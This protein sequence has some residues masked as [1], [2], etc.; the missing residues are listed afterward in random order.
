MTTFLPEPER[1]TRYFTVIS[2]D[3]HIVEPPEMFLRRV[4]TKFVARAPRV[5]REA[6]G[7]EMWLYDGELIPNIGLNAVA[8]RPPR[9]YSRDPVTFDDMRRG[10]W[11]IHA[12]IADMDLDGVFA[13]LNFPSFLTGFGGGRLQTTTKDQDL[14]LAV[15][16]AWNDWHLEEWAGSYPDRIIPCQITWLHNPVLAA[17]DVERNR[18]R[19]FRAL[20]FPELPDRLG[21]PPVH[22]SFWDPLFAACEAT[23]T[24]VCLHAGS[25]GTLL[26]TSEGAPREATAAFFGLSAIIPA[27]DWLFA[28]VPVRFP[29]LKIVLAESGIGWVAA[30]LDR[31]DHLARY[32]ECYG[33][34]RGTDL[35]PSE[36]L[37]RN[38]WFCMLDNPSSLCQ[39][40]R[41][42]IHNIL[43]EVDYP[44]ADSSWPNTQD[45]LRR[46]LRA[47][48]PWEVDQV[49]WKNAS[50]LF[51]FPV[52]QRVRRDPNA[53]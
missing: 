53:F 49:T 51:G 35:S 7:T 27:I 6:D 42:G 38:F 10:A 36:V 39:K 31:L 21:F 33:D 17:K 48:E 28:L 46:Q 25:G 3:D 24:V 47:L 52:P 30:L 9:E 44:H 14:A 34:W 22:S 43:C 13:S 11:D 29:E 1:R 16:R 41:I 37:L 50:E 4:P 8:G 45:S 23:G 12:R 40:E 18:E 20:S 5:V 19:G 26:G 2:V 32:H 15:I